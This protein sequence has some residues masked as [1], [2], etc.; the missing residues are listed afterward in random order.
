MSWASESD[1]RTR[2]QTVL[3]ACAELLGSRP[4]AEVT[5]K[6]VVEA[7]G[8]P[9]WSAYRAVQRVARSRDHL[10]RR[11]V[12]HLVE[13]I[14]SAIKA[15]PVSEAGILGT[16]EESVRHVA[17][18][19]KGQP[20]ATLFR[21]LL[22]EGASNP[23]LRAEYE[24]VVAAYSR[25]LDK[26]LERA[27]RRAGVAIFFRGEA[28]RIVLRRLEVELLLPTLLP[29]DHDEDEADPVPAIARAIFELSYAWNLDEAA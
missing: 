27:G 8:L 21:L 17:G 13:E 29:G 24:K 12:L 2:N 15:A 22:G 7:S 9:P 28:A 1:L 10:V 19:V 20:F 11:A 14:C 3:A 16:I 25:A 6:A 23:W 18:V 4:A 26:A 5:I